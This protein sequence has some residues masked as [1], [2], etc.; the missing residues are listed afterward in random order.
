MIA[1]W[2]CLWNKLDTEWQNNQGS[3]QHILP[4]W[5]TEAKKIWI[6]NSRP[7]DR[8]DTS[9][10]DLVVQIYGNGTMISAAKN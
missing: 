4:V 5:V 10:I 2:I 7:C 8:A 9:N 6:L 3:K 1:P